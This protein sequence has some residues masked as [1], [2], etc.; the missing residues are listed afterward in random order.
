M[1]SVAFAAEPAKTPATQSKAIVLTTAQMDGVTA[2]SHRGPGGDG[3]L[4]DVGGVDVDV[5]AAVCAV[6]KTLRCTAG[7]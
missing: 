2:G 6:V 5:N 1:T 7:S 4:I 3:T